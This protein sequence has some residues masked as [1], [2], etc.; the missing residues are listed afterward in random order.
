MSRRT[1]LPEAIPERVSRCFPTE[2]ARDL[3][4]LRRDLHQYP[5]LSFEEHRTRDRL[6]AFL[7]EQPDAEITEIAETGLVA[8]VPGRDPDAPVVAV[9]GDIDALPIAERTGLPW[10]SQNEGVMHACGH[11]V[12]A[13]WAAGAARL[14][15]EKPAAGDV[16][17]VFQPGEE[18]GE[19]ARRVLDSG[20]LSEVQAIFGGHVDRD[21]EV[22]EAVVKPGPIAASADFFDVTIRG[23]GG[24]AARPHQTSD[25]L[26]AA[27][28]AVLQLNAAT[29][30]LL[31]PDR[32][33]TLTVTTC[34]AG[35]SRNVIP[36]T[37]ELAGTIRATDRECREL[38]SQT[39]ERV[40]RATAEAHDVE[41]RLDI[42]RLV[43]PLICDDRMA[44]RAEEAARELLGEEG[45]VP[46]RTVN[47]AGEDFAHYLEESPGCFL[48]IG[49]REPGGER[50]PAHS[51]R[52]YAADGSIFVGAAVL[53]G[54]ARRTSSELG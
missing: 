52:F 22:G 34:R 29:Q 42:T 40:V 26:G 46:L 25:P 33:G 41:A 16:L 51:P 4:E 31:E 12:H 24:H 3:L 5:E 1:P 35:E 28:A 30:R 50:V 15:S 20:A 38:L 13:T 17:V 47:L 7:R 11:D 27:A 44:H 39:L 21:Y 18:S 9:R 45:V 48:R 8:R 32:H 53:A 10:T 36:E 2:L 19:G 54:A 6:R 43:P 23:S 37:A 14:L 49:A